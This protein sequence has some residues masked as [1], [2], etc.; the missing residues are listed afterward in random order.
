M[1]EDSLFSCSGSPPAGGQLRPDKVHEPP[2]ADPHVRW[3]GKKG[4]RPPLY[5]IKLALIILINSSL[6][7]TFSTDSIYSGSKKTWLARLRIKLLRQKAL[8]RDLPPRKSEK[9][10]TVAFWHTASATRPIL[11]S[12][13]IER[14]HTIIVP[15]NPDRH[16][17]F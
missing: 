17:I 9:T 5:P 10:V 2:D 11:N 4:G 12:F 3:C 1:G 6:N 16:F 8:A 7:L 13:Y 15:V 14:S